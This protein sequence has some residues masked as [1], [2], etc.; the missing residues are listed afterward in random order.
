MVAWLPLP[1]N[2][3]AHQCQ[4]PGGGYPYLWQI[5]VAGGRESGHDL[6]CRPTP[7]HVEVQVVA[8]VKQ[9]AQ[10]VAARLALVGHDP[11]WACLPC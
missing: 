1:G 9:G 11:A 4:G 10:S 2:L 7:T 8:G 5:I 6:L 3:V